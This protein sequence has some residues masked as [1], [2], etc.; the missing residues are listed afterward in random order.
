LQFA[1]CL[2]VYVA[3]NKR[4]ISLLSVLVV[5]KFYSFFPFVYHANTEH[6]RA[7]GYPE[8]VVTWRREDGTEIVM[9]DSQGTKTHGEMTEDIENR[10]RHSN[11]PLN[12]LSS[13]SQLHHSEEKF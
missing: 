5:E 7:R 11:F 8:P 13:L 10:L 3:Q 9:K 4:K 6:R 1:I 2:L 12:F